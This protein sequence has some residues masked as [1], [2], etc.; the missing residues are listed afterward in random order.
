MPDLVKCLASTN[1]LLINNAKNSIEI[2]LSIFMA[3][4]FLPQQAFTE[5]LVVFIILVV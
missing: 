5:N 3:I 4:D 2:V 1:P